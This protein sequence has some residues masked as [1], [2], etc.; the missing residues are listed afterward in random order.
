[1]VAQLNVSTLPVSLRRWT[2]QTADALQNS[3]LTIKITKTM[4]KVLIR[5]NVNPKQ[6]QIEFISA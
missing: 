5:S 3:D 4:E 1:M 2:A 6:A